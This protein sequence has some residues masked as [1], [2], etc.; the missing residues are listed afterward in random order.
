MMKHI[1]LGGAAAALLTLD[2]SGA[3]A[4]P[5]V[6]GDGNTTA[7]RLLLQR[8]EWDRARKIGGYEDPI[9]ALTNLFNGT[10]T[11]R[12]IQ[13]TLEA[14]GNETFQDYQERI[15]KQLAAQE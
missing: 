6:G 3:Q 11:K 8:A 15:D 13:P 12:T 2:I 14:V 4:G 7:E 1:L 5:R 10:A 9:T